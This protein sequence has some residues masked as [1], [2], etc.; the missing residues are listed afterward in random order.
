MG[1]AN[2]FVTVSPDTIYGD[3][4]IW[5]TNLSEPQKFTAPGSGTIEVSEIGIW[6]QNYDQF[7]PLTF[8]LAIYTHDASNDCPETIVANSDTGNL[9]LS[10]PSMQKKSYTYG[11]KP[12]LTGGTTYWLCMASVNSA[13][14]Y[15]SDFATGGSTIERSFDGG[16]PPDASWHSHTD[17]AYDTS[18][19][20]VYTAGGG[21]ETITLN[22][23]GYAYVCK[24][25]NLNIHEYYSLT[26]SSQV[27]TGEG[28]NINIGQKIQATVMALIY[29]GQAIN[30]NI[31]ETVQLT[32]QTL[33]WVGQN[34]SFITG[35]FVQLAKATLT[36]V[37]KNIFLTEVLRLTKMG[38]AWAGNNISFF[39]E[40]LGGLI[41]TFRR[42]RRK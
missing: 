1:A 36:L 28:V 8:K 33:T 11:T 12:Q 31:H 41:P 9:S 3:T 23:M 26:K 29:M 17:R 34:I 16:W 27:W 24:S 22:K 37:G 35:Q 13:N 39:G 18:I 25:I 4:T 32:K 2:G 20:A 21:G 38:I 6:G 15:Y 10:G 30:I 19:Y 14:W 42:R 40:A 7:S 5:A